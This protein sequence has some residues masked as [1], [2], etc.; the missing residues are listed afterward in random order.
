MFKNEVLI[1]ATIA[2]EDSKMMQESSEEPGH[3]CVR[4]AASQENIIEGKSLISQ[5]EERV[6][7]Q[8]CFLQSA[9]ASP[10]YTGG[11]TQ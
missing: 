8:F 11:H 10:R 1:G 4:T 3:V 6:G 9:C 7:L 5:M 2:K